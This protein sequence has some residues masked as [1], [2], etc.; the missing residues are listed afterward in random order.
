MVFFFFALSIAE[1]ALTK[2]AVCD[3][4]VVGAFLSDGERRSFSPDRSRDAA[5]ARLH[6]LV[7]I[8]A[9]GADNGAFA[10][11]DLEWDR[12]QA[13]RTCQAKQ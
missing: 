11:D 13:G 12:N 1:A 8:D 10:I 9:M 5:L 7:A 6:P 3:E 2:I 4:R